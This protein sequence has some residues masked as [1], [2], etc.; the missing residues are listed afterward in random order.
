ML[1]SSTKGTPV[2]ICLDFPPYRIVTEIAAR[3]RH[4]SYSYRVRMVSRSRFLLAEL[5][6]AFWLRN[7]H[8]Y[9]PEISQA[10]SQKSATAIYCVPV[11]PNPHSHVT[12]VE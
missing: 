10:F 6:V 3:T 11:E 9:G 12:I 7:T 2:W 8:P 5:T 1:M 4:T